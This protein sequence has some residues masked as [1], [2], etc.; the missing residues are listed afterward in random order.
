MAVLSSHYSMTSQSPPIVCPVSGRNY[1]IDALR[2]VAM[3]MVC[4][5]HMNLFTKAHFEVVPTK[6][7]F[8]YFGIWTETVGM[9]GVN[10]YA[11]I[12]GYV[13]VMSSWRYS[14]YVRLWVLV[15][16]YTVLL[17]AIGYALS[18]A[19][20][21]PY[22][23]GIVQI[24][25]QICRLG[26]GSTYWYFAA[27]TGLFFIIPFLNLGLQRL[28]GEKFTLL[29]MVLVVLLP[30]INF[31]AGDIIYSGGYNMIWLTALYVVGAYIKLYPPR[32]LR[33]WWLLLV[34]GI[35]TLQPLLFALI[36][37]PPKNGYTWPVAVVYSISLFIFFTRLEFKSGALKRVITWAAPAS[38]SVYLLHV[39]PWS[40][41]MLVKYVPCV[42][43]AWDH[44]W[45]FPLAGGLV[46]YLVCTMIDMLRMRVFRVCRVDAVADYF[47]SVIENAVR[48]TLNVLSRL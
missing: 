20:V 26:F 45:W 10:L 47:A 6:E 27:Y 39:H 4:V 32:V 17:F 1:G 29:V 31:R 18:L 34:A 24:A 46:M 8:Y 14:R 42:N 22:S 5:I 16:F 43:I 11:M 48:R 36:G 38:F 23:C 9:I 30:I 15:A 40:W 21:L 44:P 7:Y 2:I 3:L 35:C 37:L 12:T 33:S 41:S 28:S 13:C 19:D 25:K